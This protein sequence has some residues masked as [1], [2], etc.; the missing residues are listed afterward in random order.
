M[1]SV[2]EDPSNSTV[3]VGR[4]TVFVGDR[5]TAVGGEF[6]VVVVDPVV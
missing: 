1:S 4:S 2:E 5:I 3:F 6:N